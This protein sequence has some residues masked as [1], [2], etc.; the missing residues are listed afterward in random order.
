MVTDITVPVK[1]TRWGTAM[2][3]AVILAAGE[4][5]RLRPF[6]VNKPKVMLSVAGKPIL[7]YV[8]EALVKNGIRNI[9]LIVGYR[10]E[11]VYN[12]FGSG[13]DFGADIVYVTQEKQVGTAHA[14]AQ[15]RLVTGDEF[16]VLPG[17]NLISAETIAE[18]T[19]V[20]PEAILVKKTDNPGRYGMI[21]A[22]N[23]LVKDIEEKPRDARSSIV[24]T[25]I[26]AFRKEVFTFIQNDLDI[27]D[28][29]NHMI[30]QDYPIKTIKTEGT[31]LDV[32]YP[33][34]LLS[35]NDSILS[36]LPHK[37]AGTVESGATIKPPVS[38]GKNTIIRSGSFITGPVVIG[39][40]CDIGP[41][42]SIQPAT[43]IGDNVSISPLCH[44][45]NSVI[46]NDVS[47][48]PGCII[49]D[50]VIDR[51]SDITGRFTAIS[52]TAD[53]KVDD[54]YHQ[55]NIGAM[56]GEDCTLGAGVVAQPGVIVGNLCRIQALKLINGRLPDK[57]LVF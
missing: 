40:N 36:Q 49:Q 23:S 35:L 43:S 7:S 16:L 4:G 20:K 13:A 21:T 11:Q 3:Q 19:D 54:E 8:I 55:V 34:D 31:W 57:S 33:W 52:G 18:F 30:V 45:R 27:P 26:Y 42:V 47:I 14:L 2:K 1:K 51:G 12:Y 28:V 44:I 53:I 56:L 10:K 6:T 17:D 38:I 41:H 15:A 50:S 5:T 48:G 22:E 39:N 24:S 32:V 9:I 25:G 29:I 46:S 37:L